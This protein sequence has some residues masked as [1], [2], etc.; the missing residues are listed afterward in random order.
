MKKLFALI[1]AVALMATMSVTAFAA[2]TTGGSTEVSFNVD[3]TYTIT[4]PATVE[5][6]KKVD[7]NTVTYENDYTIE[8]VAGVRLLKNE[9][10]EVAVASD[11]TMQ[12][13]EGATLAYS[14]TAGGN[15]VA[16][17]GVVAEFAT[18]KNA[19]SITIHIAANDPDFAGEYNDTVTFTV[20]VKDV[21]KP[22]ISFTIDGTSYQAEEGMTWGDWVNSE[23]DNDEF[24]VDINAIKKGFSF[25]SNGGSNIVYTDN[26]I[27]ANAA[28]V[29]GSLTE[30]L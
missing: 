9:Y 20:A 25:V 21:P 7:G 16:N 10:I 18:D 14:I 22:L 28:Y 15:A 30:N 23:Y 26:Q 17:N 2:N 1:L 11:F 5:L 12:T 3:P 29:F 27:T 6:Q 4:I 24:R 13:T 19:Q 8:A